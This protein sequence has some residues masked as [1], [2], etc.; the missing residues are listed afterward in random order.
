MNKFSFII[1]LVFIIIASCSS[2]WSRRD[3][4]LQPEMVLDTIGVKS[5]MVIGEVGAGEGY[6]TFKL[7]ARVGSTGKIYANDI[8][9]SVLKSIQEKAEKEH[10]ENINTVLGETSDPL[11]PI[12]TLDMIVM[13]MVYHDLT[14]PVDFMRNV[15]HYLKP[16]SPVIIIDR[17]PERW[18]QGHDHFMKKDVLIESVEKADYKLSR[19]ETFPEIDNVYIFYPL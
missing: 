1:T 3:K 14:K 17:D 19:I 10:I 7:S 16:G 4:Q 12:N 11:F 13:I 8:K 5:G 15:K 2:Q 9:K 18:G 6:L